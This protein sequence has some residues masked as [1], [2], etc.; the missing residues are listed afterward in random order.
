MTLVVAAFIVWALAWALN[1]RLANGPARGTMPVRIAVPL[2]FGLTILAVW[3]LLVR[4]L[5]VQIGRAHV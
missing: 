4:G 2:L 3:E 1:R 5:T